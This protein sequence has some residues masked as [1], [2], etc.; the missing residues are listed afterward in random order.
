M[1]GTAPRQQPLH[2]RRPPFGLA[3]ADENRLKSRGIRVGESRSRRLGRRALQC[4]GGFNI[5][6][7]D[8]LNGVRF[9]PDGSVLASRDVLG[10]FKIWDVST[11][12]LL[13][14]RPKVDVATGKPLRGIVGHPDQ[15]NSAAF[16]PDGR[17]LTTGGGYTTHP[18]PVNRASDARVWDVKTGK[19][20]YVL[21]WRWGGGFLGRFL[22]QRKNPLHRLIRWRRAAS[23]GSIELRR[24][25]SRASSDSKCRTRII[26]RAI[27]SRR[28]P[29]LAPARRAWSAPRPCGR[30]GA[31]GEQRPPRWLE[32]ILHNLHLGPG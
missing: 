26:G 12:K 20:L 27:P 18:W 11:G 7:R 25:P 24:S 1:E 10:P 29:R 5:A 23:E 32:S 30:R 22:A 4:R 15:L 19:L 28:A 2:C 3:S 8:P 6:G 17:F 14:A 13:E 31:R 21:G 9:S 16:S